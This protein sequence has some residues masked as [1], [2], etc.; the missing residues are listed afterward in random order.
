[1]YYPYIYAAGFCPYLSSLPSMVAILVCPDLR[2][3]GCM[4]QHCLFVYLLTYPTFVGQTLSL[5]LSLFHSLS[6]SLSLFLSLF[7]SLSLFLS[8]SLSFTLSLSLILSPRSLSFSIYIS[9]CLSLSLCVPT[10]LFK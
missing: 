2:H 6:L 4:F 7:Y 3:Q 1:M 8:L 5:F 9:I 10:Y